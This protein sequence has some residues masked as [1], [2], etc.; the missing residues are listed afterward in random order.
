MIPTA[1]EFLRRDE[2]GV[3]SEQDIVHAMIEFAKLHCEKQAKEI[4]RKAW[5]QDTHAS[6]ELEASDVYI[7]NEECVLEAYPLTNIK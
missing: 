3:Y 6:G 5:V 1:I 7:V 4:A 2:S